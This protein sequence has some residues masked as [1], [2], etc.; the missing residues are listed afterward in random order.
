VAAQAKIAVEVTQKVRA[1][2]AMAWVSLLRRIANRRTARSTIANK[3]LTEPPY[4]KCSWRIPGVAYH[5]PKIQS[6]ASY[7]YSQ[8]VL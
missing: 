6:Y 2:V 3:I 5:G 7:T 4:V 8:P 1:I